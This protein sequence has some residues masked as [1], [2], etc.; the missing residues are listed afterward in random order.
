MAD[1]AA[2]RVLEAAAAL[3]VLDVLSQTSEEKKP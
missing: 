1:P 3:R 2:N